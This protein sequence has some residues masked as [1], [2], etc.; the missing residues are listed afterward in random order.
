M[1]QLT[2]LKKQIK[3]F[4]DKME[5]LTPLKYEDESVRQDTVDLKSKTEEVLE[6]TID[7][8]K[9]ILKGRP[10]SQ[11][12]NQGMSDIT[13]IQLTGIITEEQ[14]KLYT[15]KYK[16]Y[17]MILK[18]LKQVGEKNGY[19]VCFPS[20]DNAEKTI[21]NL[22]RD[23]KDFLDNYDFKNPSDKHRSMLTETDENY[24]DKVN[25]QIQSFLKNNEA[26]VTRI[27]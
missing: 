25:H 8:L 1:T 17:P 3:L 7:A 4:K 16:D 13:L 22:E 5:E 27:D 20:Q 24:F 2:I 19:N 14:L 23:T 26:T 11:A 10:T 9:A 15:N 18:Y 12:N 21:D 6:E